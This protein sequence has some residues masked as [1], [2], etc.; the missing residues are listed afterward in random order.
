MQRSAGPASFSLP[1]CQAPKL[2]CAQKPAASPF[3]PHLL[4]LV[5]GGDGQAG[6]QVGDLKGSVS[7]H[8]RTR[9]RQQ[10]GGSE[11]GQVGRIR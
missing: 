4:Q 7:R 3:P 11:G 2:C 8:R 6:M 1:R 5:L 10:E 9:C